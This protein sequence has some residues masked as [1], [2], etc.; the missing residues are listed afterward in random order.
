M[1]KSVFVS[2]ILYNINDLIIQALSHLSILMKPISIQMNYYFP[3]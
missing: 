3:Q 2:F 1:S